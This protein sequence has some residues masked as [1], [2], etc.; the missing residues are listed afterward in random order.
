MFYLQNHMTVSYAPC[1]AEAGKR[2]QEYLLLFY[3]IET[4]TAPQGSITVCQA[5][6]PQEHYTLTVTDETIVITAGD[7]KGAVY[8]V[9]HLLQSVDRKTLAIATQNLTEKPYKQMR[10]V[11]VYL[12]SRQNIGAFKR[13][14]EVMAFFK[15][16]TVIM[17]ISGGMEYKRH[18][19]INTTWEWF[20][21]VADFRFPGEGRSRSVQWSDIY[22]KDSIH[23]EH[24]GA[25]YLTQEEVADLAA[26]ARSLGM[27][28]IPEIQALSHSYYLT[29]PHREIAE[30]QD[31]MFPDSYCP[32][33]EKSY[34]LYFEV[35]EEVINVLKPARVSVGHDEVRVLGQCEKCRQKTGHELLAYELNRLH[36]FYSAHGIKMLMWGEMLQHYNDYKGKEVGTAIDR[37]ND[38]GFHYTLP[39]TYDARLSIPKDITM[40]D[41]QYSRGHATERLFTD[42]G[43]P[44][45]FGNFRGSRILNWMK[46]SA[47][48]GVLGAEVS[49]WVVTDEETFAKDGIF[50]EIMYSSHMLWEKDYT[51][52]KYKEMVLRV[53][54][55]MF[56]TKAIMSGKQDLLQ[57]GAKV[58]QVLYLGEKDKAFASFDT[59][60]AVAANQTVLD[61]AAALGDTLYGVPVDTTAILLKKEFKADALL[62]LHSAKQ[63][64]IYEPSHRFPDERPLG[65]GTYVVLYED[66]TLEL[67]NMNFG[68]TIGHLGYR[69][70]CNNGYADSV[71]FEIDDDLGEGKSG[72]QAPTFTPDAQ[73]FDSVIYNTVPLMD[74][75]HTIYAYQWINPH[76]EKKIIKLKAIN[77]CRNPQQT[78]LTFAILT[79]ER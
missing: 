76:P 24:A 10:G 32:L 37:Y 39:A 21:D 51:E 13:I 66:G 49:T 2:L 31:D 53:T 25:S 34:E 62:F 75:E 8:G 77:T 29:L 71:S 3:G 70:H 67:A 19:E 61:T 6:L 30:L 50:F 7:I 79:L 42:E 28:V 56:F 23:T 17:E 72:I 68:S 63:D 18:P 57:R 59:T 43:F 33:N 20:C 47:N 52:D 45:M 65:I 12:P 44:M 22:W 78:G 15:M 9:S 27:E 11:H 38:Y 14:L 48:D 4:D 35:A 64:M 5:E 69:I 1:F 54:D 26:H 58:G 55:E 60:K 74:E 16:N 36:E 73:W 40:L 41:W 46:R